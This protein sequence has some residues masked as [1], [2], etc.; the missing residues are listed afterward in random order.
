MDIFLSIIWIILVLLWLI[1]CFVPILAGPLLSFL[2]I[3]ALEIS[4]KSF[5]LEFLIIWGIIVAIVSILDNIIP[6]LWT[7]KMGGSKFWVRGS[8]IWL[9]VAVIILPFMGI[10]IWPF[11]L[12]GIIGWPFLW[13]WIWEYINKKNR[14]KSFKPAIGAFLGFLTWIILKFIVS[15]ILTYYFILELSNGIWNMFW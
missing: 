15:L 14:E 12:I 13:A 2:W 11:G 3:I 7:K 6:V 1:G 8:I 4:F 10:I 5:S 9:I